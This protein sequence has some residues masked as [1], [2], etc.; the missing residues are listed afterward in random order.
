M[1]EFERMII[2]WHQAAIEGRIDEIKRERKNLGIQI[3]RRQKETI[4]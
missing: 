1:D 3:F 2:Q 4:H